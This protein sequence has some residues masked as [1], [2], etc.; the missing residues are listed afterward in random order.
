MVPLN[1]QLLS[2]VGFFFDGIYC[3]PLGRR[4]RREVGRKTTAGGAPGHSQAL[5]GDALDELGGGLGLG[6]QAELL[7][8][9]DALLVVL[10]LQLVELFGQLV[11]LLLD[12]LVLHEL[13]ERLGGHHRFGRLQFGHGRRRRHRRRRRRHRRRRRRTFGTGRQLGRAVV[14]SAHP[15]AHHRLAFGRILALCTQTDAR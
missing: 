14:G 6:D 11:A 10:L 8:D 1:P 15:L 9:L 4:K 7:L 5:A 13:V 3:F 12:R 2:F